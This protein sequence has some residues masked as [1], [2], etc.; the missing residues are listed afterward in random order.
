MALPAESGHIQRSRRGHRGTDL[1]HP[2]PDRARQAVAAALRSQE[3]RGRDTRR[4]NRRISDLRRSQEDPLRV[5][6]WLLTGLPRARR[7]SGIVD[8]GKFTKGDGALTLGAISVRVEPRAEWAQIFRE[9]WRINR[10]YFY[11]TNMH[12]ADWNAMLAQVRRV[13]P[14]P[15]QPGRPEPRDPDDAQRAVGR[16]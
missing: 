10:D 8:A 9:A 15:G 14:A 4:G 1:L 16:P 13:A 7:H 12:G 5:R 2:P 6:R 11:A 3:A